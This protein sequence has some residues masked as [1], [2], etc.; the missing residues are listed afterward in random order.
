MLF[1]LIISREQHD[2]QNPSLA[3]KAHQTLDKTRHSSLNHWHTFRYYTRPYRSGYRKCFVAPAIDRVESTDQSTSANQPRSYSLR[4]SMPLYKV[5]ERSPSY[6]SARYLVAL[7]PG[8]VWHVL[9]AEIA[10]EAK[11]FT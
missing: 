5:L 1:S 7:A 10:R 9:T 11:D 6:R 3:I 4:V 8:I 2:G